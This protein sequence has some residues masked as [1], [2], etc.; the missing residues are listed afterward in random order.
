MRVVVAL[1]GNAVLRK[2]ES[3]TSKEIWKN[4]RTAASMLAGP[5][6][7][8]EAV[9]THGNGPQVGYLLEAM[10]CASSSY[11]PQDID[12]ADAM[13][14]GWLGYMIQTALEEAL[15]GKRRVVALLTRVLV[16]AND[17]SLANPT[18][19]IGRFLGR[20]EAETLSRKYGW[21]FREDPRG[22]YRRVVASPEPL[23]VLEA[24]IIDSLL[25]E[26]Y[27]VVAGGGGGIPLISDGSRLVPVEGVVDKDLTS[28]L[29][30]IDLKADLFVTLTDVEGVAVN[31]DKPDMRWLREVTVSEL[32]RLYQEGQ[33]PAGSMGPKVLAAI[34]FVETTGRTAV[35]GNLDRAPDV[36][37]GR[38]GTVVVPG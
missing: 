29:L 20:G 5:I 8:K 27:I 23:E 10:T 17:P 12:A 31:Y 22:G 16:Q 15:L 25:R 7:D 6:A 38:A 4:I 35:I 33:F 19:F 2:G 3:G 36:I 18:K 30:A 1:G 28:S 11:P 14:Q 37:A 34:R 24:P 21:T 32:R 9:I 13:T 26:R